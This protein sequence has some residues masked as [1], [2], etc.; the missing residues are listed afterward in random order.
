MSYHRHLCTRCKP[1]ARWNCGG[2]YNPRGP[3]PGWHVGPRGR[4]VANDADHP[5]HKVLHPEVTP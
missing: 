5:W 3:C 1:P 2:P 4:L